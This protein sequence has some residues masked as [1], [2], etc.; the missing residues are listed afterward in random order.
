MLGVGAYTCAE[1]DERL[2]LINDE[3]DREERP[4]DA[5]ALESARSKLPNAD[6]AKLLANVGFFGGSS[7]VA[8]RAAVFGWAAAW[9]DA[10]RGTDRSVVAT[11]VRA[12]ARVEVHPV[13]ALTP[14]QVDAMDDWEGHPT[15]YRRVHYE[16]RMLLEPDR[17]AD[18]VQ[19]YLGTPERRRALL[20]ADRHVLCADV[21]YGDVDLLVA[22]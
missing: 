2:D 1:I 22:R 9:C 18:D 19:V 15:Y 4:G 20:V 17:R 3:L 16:G 21:P 13:F 8:V 11:L 12:P 10:R 6:P 7:V 5:V 14:H